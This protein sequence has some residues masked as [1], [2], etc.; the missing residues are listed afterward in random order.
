MAEVEAEIPSGHLDSFARDNLP[1]RD[2]WPDLIFTREEFRSPARL[3]CVSA[4]LDRWVAEVL[5]R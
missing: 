3:N 1:P 4:L 5:N 2:Q